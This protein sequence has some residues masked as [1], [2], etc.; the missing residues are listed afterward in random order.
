MPYL[1][2]DDKGAVC[3]DC[4]VPVK[5]GAISVDADLCEFCSDALS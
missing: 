5:G 4:I 3:A 2:F 1:F